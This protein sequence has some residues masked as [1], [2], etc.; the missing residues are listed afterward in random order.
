MKTYLLWKSWYLMSE[1]ER[2]FMMSDS[3]LLDCYLDNYN[4]D[5]DTYDK[6]KFEE[7]CSFVNDNYFD[8]DFGDSKYSNWYYSSLK[9][10]KVAVIG[11]LGLWNGT[12]EIKPTGFENLGRAIRTCLQD[13]NE[14]YEDQYGNLHIEAH[15]HDGVNHFIIK[16]VVD[17]KLKCLHFRREVFGC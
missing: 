17:G 1:E 3:D 13:E 14:I 10:Q 11:T 12:H 2:N 4:E 5:I 6:E 8:D 7:Y 9:D 15:H 16:K